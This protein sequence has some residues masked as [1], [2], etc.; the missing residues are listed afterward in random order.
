MI[1]YPIGIRS[2][3]IK[4][5]NGLSMHILEAGFE[6]STNKPCVI[7]L[8][9]FPELAIAGEKSSNWQMLVTM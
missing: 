1:D 4:N 2:R 5:I 8:H 3:I 9:G 7:L 6:E